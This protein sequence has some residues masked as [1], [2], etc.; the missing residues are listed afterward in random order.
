VASASVG[1]L[2]GPS[3]PPPSAAQS[4]KSYLPHGLLLQI[5]PGI[6]G[7]KASLG[8]AKGLF[9][10]AGAG[11]KASV[12]RTWGHPVFV[13]PRRT[14]AGVEVDASFF[15]K[16][17]LG[18]LTRVGGQRPAPSVLVTGGIGIGF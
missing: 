10:F 18:V 1:L 16:L 2:I 4:D 13:E 6:G 3:D 5:E 14:Y 11:V 17:S 9:P 7:G 12:L 8:Y 15:V